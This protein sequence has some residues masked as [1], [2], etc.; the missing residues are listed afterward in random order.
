MKGGEKL[1]PA[2]VVAGG[3]TGALVS[4]PEAVGVV[5]A[6]DGI[7]AGLGGAA[8][9]LAS[10]ALLGQA[11]GLLAW[12]AG[13]FLVPGGPERLVQWVRRGLEWVAWGHLAPGGARRLLAGQ[14]AALP[15]VAGTLVLAFAAGRI[16]IEKL[17]N[18]ELMALGIM[19]A[20]LGGALAFALLGWVVYRALV[21][22]MAVLSL[23][24]LETPA[25][26]LLLPVLLVLVLAGVIGGMQVVRLAAVVNLSWVPQVGI[27]LLGGSLVGLALT[28]W[29]R[30]LPGAARLGPGLL[31]WILVAALGN[32]TSARHPVQA[33]GHE[34]RLV[35]S[36]AAGLSDVDGDGFGFLF[37]GTDCGPFDEGIHPAAREIPGNGID[38]NCNG[39]DGEND[40]AVDLAQTPDLRIE[41]KALFPVAPNVLFISMDAARA[42]RFSCY[43]HKTRTTPN[44]DRLARKSALFRQAFSPG[45]NTHSSVPGIL[46]GKNIFS[47]ALRRDEKSRMLILLEDENVTMAELLKEQGYRTAAVVSHRFFTKKHKWN[48]G[49][50][51]Y[52]VTVRSKRKTVSSPRVL[53]KAREFID[54][55][56][57][58]HAEDPFFLWAHFYDPHADYMTHKGVPFPT[59]TTAERYD[60]ELWFTDGYVQ[61]LID[62]MR[63]LD[64]PTVI[65]VTAD[66][67]E[68]LGERGS[69]GQH[70][71][72]HRENT[73]V[74]LIIH[75]PGLAPQ[76]IPETVSLTD[77]LPTLA[78]LVGA[79]IPDGVRG[80]SLLPGLFEG[81]MKGRGPVFS[82]VAWRF[83][84]PPEHW[85]AVTLGRARL[86]QE[87]RSNRHQLYFIDV[88]PEEKN[89]LAGQGY[90]EEE[91]LLEYLKQFLETTTIPTAETKR[92]P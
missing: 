19:L 42:D 66:H 78:D 43:G 21:W 68:E 88:D 80:V 7:G 23:P 28:P 33:G 73:H 74:P 31:P 87:M 14:L 32:V 41:A 64:R 85:I 34:A 47:V 90:P 46:T 13:W 16:I 75:V 76:V 27:I 17:H 30:S 25:I 2:L 79:P 48:Q 12:L 18:E 9:A 22:A 63:K 4:I 11:A 37:G 72:V 53:A 61:Q 71:T 52:S 39:S 38:E 60:G 65:I 91:E 51:R 67:G 45:P 89:D 69:S 92:I 81:S 84:K 50:D 1:L 49:F 20:H 15:M 44:V 58:G 36:F 40:L 83:E 82:E 55:H 77:V 5:R 35:L 86:L 54:E 59:K 57:A 26:V 29:V 8:L 10:A 56:A 70:R 24:R 6:A 3:F 62:A